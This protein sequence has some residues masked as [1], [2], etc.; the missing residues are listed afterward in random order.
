VHTDTHREFVAL[1]VA[2]IG[3]SAVFCIAAFSLCGSKA[4]VYNII[5]IV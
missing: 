3:L 5:A 4:E 2:A 1:V